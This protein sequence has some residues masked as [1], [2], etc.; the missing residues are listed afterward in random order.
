MSKDYC[1]VHFEVQFWLHFS[2]QADEDFLETMEVAKDRFT[3][4]VNTWFIEIPLENQPTIWKWLF[5]LSRKQLFLGKQPQIVVWFP[6]ILLEKSYGSPQF[7]LYRAG[8][9]SDCARVL[10]TLV[11]EFSIQCDLP[12]QPTWKESTDWMKPQ[13]PPRK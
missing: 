10:D 4:M 9:Q 6:G 5:H 8:L 11:A 1:G 13:I 12:G 2:D 3:T 7:A